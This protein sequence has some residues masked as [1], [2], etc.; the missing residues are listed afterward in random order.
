VGN[1]SDGATRDPGATTFVA[2]NRSPAPGPDATT[3][4]IDAT[5][6]RS[7]AGD[8]DD[9]RATIRS[10]AVQRD[11]SV[12]ANLDISDSEIAERLSHS[13]TQFKATSSS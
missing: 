6:D 4:S 3:T 2:R 5:T 10:C 9:A 7:S 13:H 12:A 11:V 1:G 8:Y